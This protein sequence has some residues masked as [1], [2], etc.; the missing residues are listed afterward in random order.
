[1][2]SNEFSIHIDLTYYT[3]HQKAKKDSKDFEMST[4]QFKVD[5]Y[6]RTDPLERYQYLKMPRF[7]DAAM[8]LE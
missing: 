5:D 6:Y 2:E 1:M 8:H 4:T 3:N 7:R